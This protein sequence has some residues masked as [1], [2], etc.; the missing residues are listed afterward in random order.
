MKLR[1][2]RR[3]NVQEQLRQELEVLQG[4]KT[5]LSPRAVVSWARKHPESALHREFEWDD[6]K[7][8]SAYRLYQARELIKMIA[9]YPQAA[10]PRW[11][12]LTI[13]RN[14]GGG[15]RRWEDVKETPNLRK[16]LVKDVLEEFVRL[17]D[18]YS[19]LAELNRIYH[20]IDYVSGRIGKKP[21]GRAAAA[22]S[23]ARRAAAA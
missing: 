1:K 23:R 6:S 17:R 9:I 18:R 4:R 16:V 11:V 20:A 5:V 8:A 12:S 22:V 15:Y 2:I 19:D 21:A 3:K 14:P 13:D 7:A 10:K